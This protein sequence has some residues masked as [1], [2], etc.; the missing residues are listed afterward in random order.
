MKIKNGNVC[1]CKCHETGKPAC[2]KC[3]VFHISKEPTS[4]HPND[5]NNP[6]IK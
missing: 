3:M 1:L 4:T 2:R 6:D 5:K